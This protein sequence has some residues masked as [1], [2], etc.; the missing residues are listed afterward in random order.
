MENAASIGDHLPG[1][2]VDR[3]H[4]CPRGQHETDLQLV[5]AWFQPDAPRPELAIL[6]VSPVSGTDPTSAPGD[7]TDPLRIA[8][9][10]VGGSSEC[11]KV[12]IGICYSGSSRM[13]ADQSNCADC[14]LIP[15]PLRYNRDDFLRKF[16]VHNSPTYSINF[17]SLVWPGRLCFTSTASFIYVC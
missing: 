6:L 15:C 17:V 11:H 16:V 8:T 14:R 4:I 2:A 1:S 7:G 12:N 3:V 9:K 5:V 10:E 13:G